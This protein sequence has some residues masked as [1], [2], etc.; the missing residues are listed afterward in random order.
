MFRGMLE[1]QPPNTDKDANRINLDAP[2]TYVE[3]LMNLI[4]HSPATEQS[5]L[6]WDDYKAF[7][8]LCAR[9]G[10]DGAPLSIVHLVSKCVTVSPIEIFAFASQVDNISLAKDCIMSFP[11]SYRNG[12]HQ[13]T[14]MNLSDLDEKFTEGV[15]SSY[16]FGLA[17]A[18][19]EWCQQMGTINWVQ[20]SALFTPVGSSELTEGT[21]IDR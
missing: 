20:I 13:C 7:M 9:Y 17:K 4:T 8:E 1:V 10:F 16:S 11:R 3:L 6:K 18:V 5:K 21:H 14:Y 2:G 15:A 19:G 12:S